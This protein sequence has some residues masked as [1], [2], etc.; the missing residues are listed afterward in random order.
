MEAE[1][2]VNNKG[3]QRKSNEVVP[4]R[5]T[6]PN[7]PPSYAPPLPFPQ[8]FRK[9]KLDAQFAKFLNMFKKLEINIPFADA[10]AQMPNYVKFMKEIMSNK[11]KLEAFG[12]VNLSKKCNA[13]IQQK[14]PEK[15]K[16]SGS[17]TIPCVIREHNFTKHCVI[18]DA[19]INLMSYS[20]AKRLNLGEI[21]P[22]AL[23]LQMA[24][25]SLTYP[26]G[27]IEDV[28]VKVDKFIFPV[29]FVVLDMEEDK[30]APIILGRPFLATSQA[31]IDVENG[32]LTLRVGDDQVKFNLYKGMNF[33]SDENASCMRIDTLI[34]SQYEMLY[35]FGKRSSLEQCLT[36]S[37]SIEKFDMEDLSSTPEL[38]EIVLAFEMT[39]EN[40]VMCEEKRT[41]DGLVLKEFPKGLKYDI[42]G[43]DETKPVIIS[44][45][46][47]EAMEVKLLDVLKMNSEAFA[48]NI[49]DIKGIS[50]SI[51]MHK[52]LMEEGH[53]PSIE[54]QRRLNPAMKEVVKKEVLKWLQAGF[55][56]AI[57]NSPWASLVQVVPKR[58]GMI[59]VRNEKK[60]SCCPLEQSRVGEYALII[61]NST[62]QQG[63]TI[64]HYL[65]WI[66]CW[67]D[68]STTRTIAS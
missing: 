62:R 51:C 18:L 36:K 33:L 34:P 32:E 17:F 65:S 41:P 57:S 49:E 58:R 40:F 8:K 50:P 11:R 61:E 39:E 23:S 28:L 25:R 19:S 56:Y 54:H 60:M 48:W 59:V 20:V 63:R 66:K 5:I 3:E 10:L 13:I 45:R 27:I 43:N 55:I 64:I 22:T 47:D 7:N 4:R 12:T 6:F 52:I 26:K 37:F 46:L 2:K 44:S 42:F 15:L 1:T 30:A 68:L 9:T 38:I 21:E 31:L 53:T 16:D 14:L 29:D 24:D 67:I 35:D